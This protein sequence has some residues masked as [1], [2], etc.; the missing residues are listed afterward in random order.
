MEF[1][2]E[3]TK[4]KPINK[5]K[6]IKRILLV[7]GCVFLFVILLFAALQFDRQNRGPQ[8][9]NQEGENVDGTES[10]DDEI[11]LTP[12]IS[13]TISDYQSLQN[14]LY[15]IGANVNTSIVSISVLSEENDWIE[16]SYETDWQAAGFIT[17]Q[18]N[19]Y[20]YV[21]TETR[22]IEDESN[23]KVVF[24]DGASA[25]ATLLRTDERTGMAMLTVEKRLMQPETRRAISIAKFGDSDTITSG[26]VLIALGSPLGTNYAILSGNVTSVDNRV[27]M[28]DKNYA[29]LTTDMI[30]SRNGSGVLVDINGEIVGIIAQ[31]F[32]G[33]EEV[34]ALTA[35]SVNDVKSM[36]SA[37]INGKDRAYIG[38][39]VSTVTD[40][41]S[42]EHNI[43][44]GVFVKEVVTESPAM[45]AGLQSGDVIVK[46]NDTVILTD[47]EFSKKIENLIPGTRCEIQV[48]RQSGDAY[49]DVTCEVEIGKIK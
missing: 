14:A 25:K 13:L 5:K 20:I 45:R 41:I 1:I 8:N 27:S 34:G 40:V 23:I 6:L 24:I 47:A 44:E 43:P 19:D 48:K 7:L 9:T 22:L 39:Y 18:D 10:Q 12:N 26:A 28:K 17:A 3:K 29:L 21:L 4:K 35:V 2:R 37:M 46:V 49:Y 36:V 30:T 15:E 11:E 33:A 38:L 32:A 31:S 16:E 42:K